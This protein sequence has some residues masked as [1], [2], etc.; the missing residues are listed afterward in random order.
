MFYSAWVVFSD[1]PDPG[2]IEGWTSYRWYYRWGHESGSTSMF[3][4]CTS[5]E[6]WPCIILRIIST[7]NLLTDFY[8]LKAWIEEKTRQKTYWAILWAEAI[9]CGF[10]FF[11]FFTIIVLLQLSVSPGLKPTNCISRYS[12]PTLGLVVYDQKPISAGSNEK[13][14]SGQFSGER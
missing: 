6:L 11:F 13:K 3:F 12:S 8:A 14:K 7:H 4:E 10:F 5:H 9:L 2:S 1:S